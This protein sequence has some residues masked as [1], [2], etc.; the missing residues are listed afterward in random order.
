MP[1]HSH[2]TELTVS[3]MRNADQE[4]GIIGPVVQ[5]SEVLNIE[6]GEAA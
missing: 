5:A 1:R 4:V 3:E 2:A 6:C